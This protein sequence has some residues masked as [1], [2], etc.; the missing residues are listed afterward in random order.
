[1]CLWARMFGDTLLNPC[2]VTLTCCDGVP[3]AYPCPMHW[4]HPFFRSHILSD[5]LGSHIPALLLTTQGPSQRRISCPVGQATAWWPQRPP[6]APK[7]PPRSWSTPCWASTQVRAQQ[8]CAV[9]W[10]KLTQFLLCWKRPFPQ[11]ITSLSFSEKN[12]CK[13]CS[14]RAYSGIFH[15]KSGTPDH[16]CLMESPVMME[17]FYMCTVQCSSHYLCLSKFSLTKL[18]IPFLSHNSHIP[19][20]QWPSRANGYHIGQHRGGPWHWW[21][22]WL[23]FN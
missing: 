13:M 12:P 23:S 19:S 21:L 3:S 10:G 4:A 18:T 9:S 11:S 22:G 20:A 16:C 15:M 7:V 5:Y 6:T 14:V 8:H 17:S 1:M 2:L